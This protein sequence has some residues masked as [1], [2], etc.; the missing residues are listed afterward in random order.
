MKE[1]L[2]NQDE[3]QDLEQLVHDGI[4][5]LGFM[6]DLPAN[7]DDSATV[8]RAIRQCMD[9]VRQRV[10]LPATYGDLEQAAYALGTLW[11]DEIRR[12]CGWEWVYLQTGEGF[13]GWAVA[14][15]NR[16]H[17]CFPHHFVFGKLQD[18][19]S[20]NTVALLFNMIVSW[21]CALVF[22]REVHGAALNAKSVFNTDCLKFQTPVQYPVLVLIQLGIM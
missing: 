21:S 12:A 15:P 1:R 2:P 10:P 11:G 5:C 14:S 6:V 4:E 22:S 20:D 19:Q 17:V 13:E 7:L 9:K 16:S 18:V 8:V 3:S